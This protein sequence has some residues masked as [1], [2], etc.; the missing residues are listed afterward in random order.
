M[1]VSQIFLV[2]D[3]LE[4]FEGHWSGVCRVPI[5]WDLSSVF[6]M[7]RLGLWVLGRKTME[8]KFHSHHI[9]SRVRAINMT[10][11]LMLTLT[12]CLRLCLLG[13]SL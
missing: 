10:Y 9:R 12:A 13:S 2:F 4:N 7:I 6:L 1:I 8:V 3:D 11:K 5:S